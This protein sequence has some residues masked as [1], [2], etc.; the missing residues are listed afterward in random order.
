M[1]I[2][3]RTWPTLPFAFCFM[4][5]I[6][7]WPAPQAAAK[8]APPIPSA[9]RQIQAIYNQINAAAM[10]KNV[11]GVYAF[12]SDDCTLIDQ[13]GRVHEPSEGRQDLEQALEVMDSV[14]ATTVIQGFTGTDTEATVT[15]KDHVVARIANATTGRA[16][17]ITVDD[18][19]REHWIKTE[20]GWRRNRTR[21][22]SGKNGLRK[23]F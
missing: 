8:P 22:L 15:V 5:C 21:V 9:R 3:A 19:S 16:A 17:K 1:L 6:M 13:K 18:V 7:S 20:D 14:K 12:D 4:F 11:D 10:Q 23:N 2:H